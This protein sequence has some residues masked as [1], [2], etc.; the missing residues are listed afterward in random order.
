MA[1]RRLVTAWGSTLENVELY[2][3]SNYDENNPAGTTSP[4]ASPQTMDQDFTNTTG[5]H[6]AE[7]AKLTFVSFPQDFWGCLVKIKPTYASSEN[8][9]LELWTHAGTTWTKRRSITLSDLSVG[10]RS[11]EARVFDL[12]LDAPVQGVTDVWVT[13]N[14]DGTSTNSFLGIQL[15][16]DCATSPDIPPVENPPEIE[17][18]W[19][20]E[21]PG[22]PDDPTPVFPGFTIKRSMN[23]YLAAGYDPFSYQALSTVGIGMVFVMTP[24]QSIDVTVT[25]TGGFK[26]SDAT[27][28]GP[29]SEVKT[30]TRSGSGTLQWYVLKGTGWDFGGAVAPMYLKDSEELTFTFTPKGDLTAVQLLDILYWAFTTY[31]LSDAGLG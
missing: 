21:N 2:E 14:P 31:S 4:W 7:G 18:D 13:M 25:S 17:I 10:T 1:I 22:T 26:F 8:P 29:Q 19:P 9:K 12:L 30:Q 11:G 15:Y 5:E 23:D 16:G 20:Y 28:T 3:T 24:G 27:P 6:A